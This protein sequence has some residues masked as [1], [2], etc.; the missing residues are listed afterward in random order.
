MLHD[1]VRFSGRLEP[2]FAII[3]ILFSG[4]GLALTAVSVSYAEE[5]LDS[6]CPYE[7]Q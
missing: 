1:A 4:N 7:I 6:A 3:L 5:L 2:P